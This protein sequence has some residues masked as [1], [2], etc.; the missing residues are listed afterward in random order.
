MSSSPPLSKESSHA[1]LRVLVVIHI[2]V[3]MG[4]L[5][6]GTTTRSYWL[7]ECLFPPILLSQAYSLSIWTALGGR[8]TILRVMLT[9]VILVAWMKLGYSYFW[10][11]DYYNYSYVNDYRNILVFMMSQVIAAGLLFLFFRLL[12][13]ELKHSGEKDH[14]PDR[15]QYSIWQIMT[16]TF[17]LAVFFSAQYYLPQDN[18]RIID[19]MKILSFYA[20]CLGVG[21]LSVWMAFGR[22]WFLLRALLLSSAIAVAAIT[23]NSHQFLN[24]RLYKLSPYQYDL[25]FFSTLAVGIL[26]SLFIVRWAGYR[27]TWHWRL[28]WR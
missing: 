4:C 5:L 27:M 19:N 26:F 18:I 3:A 7:S 15:L 1:I 12:G 11:R 20:S 23:E 24:T 28:R 25:P 14:P 6:L 9:I 17:I 22:K 13:L 16:W 10:I 2:M 8:R 21:M